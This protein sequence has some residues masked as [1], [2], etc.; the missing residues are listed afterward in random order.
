[1]ADLMEDVLMSPPPRVKRTSESH[2]NVP[3]SRASLA[4][5]Y[6]ETT[7]YIASSLADHSVIVVKSLYLGYDKMMR[8]QVRKCWSTACVPCHSA[9]WDIGELMSTCTRVEL[10]IHTPAPISSLLWAGNN[11]VV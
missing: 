1:M 9:V 8:S 2:R 5:M 4:T 7:S 10:I 6:K 11:T 3:Y